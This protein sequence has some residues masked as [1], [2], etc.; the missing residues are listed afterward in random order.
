VLEDE[1]VS[2]SKRLRSIH[3]S[4][5]RKQH[6]R[7]NMATPLSAADYYDFF[8]TTD[9]VPGDIWT[10]FPT[11]GILPKPTLPAL[12]ITPA[13]DL[14]NRK[15]ETITYLPIL[16]ARSYLVSRSA[17]PEIKRATEGQLTAG[18]LEGILSMP[19]GFEIPI[20]ADI[21]AALILL[22]ER[23]AQA[24][25]GQ[26]EKVSLVRAKSGLKLLQEICQ[27]VVSEPQLERL[28]SLIGEKNL[29]EAV[30]RLITN[31]RPDAH[32]LIHDEQRPEWTA[33]STHSVALFRYPLTLPI[34][35]LELAQRVTEAQ[36]P[37]AAAQATLVLP[38]LN[39]IS[40]RPMK[41]L[42]VQAAFLKDLLTRFTSMFG[43]LGSPDFTT[44]SVA[45]IAS[46][47]IED[48]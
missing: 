12:V 37:E 24:D 5:E 39:A 19:T 28:C 22:E 14:S 11:F 41:R 32:F 16:P 43:R 18:G 2:G 3:S 15:A 7:L 40:A 31:S 47:I 20:P 46:E 6:I 26:K 36:W 38:C 45:R 42:R 30:R 33:I 1:G 17:L 9:H 4:A 10:G 34:E 27:A 13:C 8:P 23:I 44:D 21:N 25:C 29:N 48:T 35:V